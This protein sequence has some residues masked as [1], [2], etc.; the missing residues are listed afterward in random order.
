MSNV[1][2]FCSFIRHME[3][4]GI[5]NSDC[6]YIAKQPISGFLS[7]NRGQSGS[8]VAILRGMWKYFHEKQP[9]S[10]FLSK[11]RGQ[12]RGKVTGMLRGMYKYF[13]IF[14]TEAGGLNTLDYI[15]ELNKT[16][17]WS[18]FERGRGGRKGMCSMRLSWHKT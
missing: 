12:S 17:S 7:S 4:G 9:M 5:N 8:Y 11:N 1:D 15:T 16:K 13:P 3:L 18:C 2:L 10:G 6:E 14:S